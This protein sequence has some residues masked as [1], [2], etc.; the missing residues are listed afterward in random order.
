MRYEAPT[1]NCENCGD[2]LAED[3]V[4]ACELCG[5]C[6]LCHNCSV[7]EEHDCTVVEDDDSSDK[8]LQR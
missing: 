4:S 6:P 5:I 3:E 7:P 1:S 8:S 2:E